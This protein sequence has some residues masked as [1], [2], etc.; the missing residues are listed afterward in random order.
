MVRMWGKYHKRK[1]Q[2][3]QEEYWMNTPITFPLI[4]A[5]DVSDG[6]LIIEAEVED[7]LVRRV[8]VDQG[9]TVQVMFEHCFD[10]LPQKASDPERRLDEEALKNKKHPA[11]DEVL[12]NPAFL[13]QRVTI[14][15]QFSP[16][17]RLQMI[18]LLKDNKDV[19][20]WKPSNMIGVPRRII[21]HSLNVN[22]SITPVAQK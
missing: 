22:L 13:E 2:R 8:F 15:M 6:P 5:N 18:Y 21:Q 4:P 20:T 1:Y 14:G 19:F 17:C 3:S 7:Y 12:V 16:A 11:E 10:N 9:A